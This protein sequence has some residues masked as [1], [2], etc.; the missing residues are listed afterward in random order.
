MK[1]I[2]LD[3]YLRL[4]DGD[5]ACRWVSS[6]IVVHQQTQSEISLENNYLRHGAK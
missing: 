3:H 6:G 2:T 5:Q 1:K 4:I